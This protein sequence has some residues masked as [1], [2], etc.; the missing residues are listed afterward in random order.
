[1]I[2]M[3]DER[4]I[5]LTV[6]VETRDSHRHQPAPPSRPHTKKTDGKTL[7]LIILRFL[8]VSKTHIENIFR[9]KFNVRSL[10]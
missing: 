5:D 3:T 9:C 2:L 8:A 4:P 10:S 7:L 1:M 6:A